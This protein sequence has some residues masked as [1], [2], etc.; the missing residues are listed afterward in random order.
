MFLKE[1]FFT[2]PYAVHKAISEPKSGLLFACVMLSRA[3]V[4]VGW[5]R[6]S[7]DWPPQHHNRGRIWP[8]LEFLHFKLS[9]NPARGDTECL[10]LDSTISF[11]PESSHRAVASV[12]YRPRGHL[13]ALVYEL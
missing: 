5:R 6:T 1:A 12:W 4:R 3:A 9:Q 7:N 10:F 8:R 2:T 11:E 13:L